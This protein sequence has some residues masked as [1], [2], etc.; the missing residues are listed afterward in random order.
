[1]RMKWMQKLVSGSEAK[2]MEGIFGV[3]SNPENHPKGSFSSDSTVILGA[4]TPAEMEKIKRTRVKWHLPIPVDNIENWIHGFIVV[5]CVRVF[6]GCHSEYK[7][8]LVRIYL[9][10]KEID[11]FELK[12]TPPQH[13]DFFHRPSLP[14][15]EA[16]GEIIR[17][18][19]V[20]LWPINKEDII[21]G[22]Q[23]VQI[24]IGKYVRW[25]IDYIGTLAYCYTEPEYDVALSFAG[26]DRKYVEQ[27]AEHLIELGVSVFYD[28][29]E[30][31][32]MW[33]KDLY[34]HLIEVYKDKALHTVMFLSRHYAKKLWPNHE[35]KAAQAKAFESEGEYILPARFDDTDIPGIL[36]T[37]SYINLNKFT[38]EKVAEMIN[39]K[40]LKTK[41]HKKN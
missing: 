23:N 36:S 25:D 2:L 5:G 39:K 38:P 15:H 30:A 10:N 20:Y 32:D 7:N 14:P 28:K 1:M 34:T 17:C 22:L 18:Q 35:R 16:I 33:G 12:Q 41:A 31:V 13:S 6:G 26:E 37:Q 9:N 3:E 19:T 21:D 29:H 27:V 4:A 11:W 8:Q 40:V 24:E